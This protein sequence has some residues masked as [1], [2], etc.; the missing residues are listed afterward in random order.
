MGL[1]LFGDHAFDADLIAFDKDGTLFDFSASLRPR[2]LAAVEQLIANLPGQSVI[3]AAL[4]RT[5]GY[6]SASGAFDARGPFCHGDRRGDRLRGN[7]GPLPTCGAE[8]RLERV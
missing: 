4:Y 2:F 5:L 7:D 8:P 3:R 6:D 1:V